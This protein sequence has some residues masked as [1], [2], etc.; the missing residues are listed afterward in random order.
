MQVTFSKATMKTADAV[1][2][3]RQD[4]NACLAPE[5]ACLADDKSDV[6]TLA[7]KL[8]TLHAKKDILAARRGR[9]EAELFALVLADVREHHKA[10]LAEEAQKVEAY[11][12][13]KTKWESYMET[14]RID[15]ANTAL[16]Y[17]DKDRAA[18]KVVR[19]AKAAVDTAHRNVVEAEKLVSGIDEVWHDA[20]RG[21]AFDP[22]YQ[23]PDFRGNALALAGVA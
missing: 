11:K 6:D 15:P 5:S 9:Q 10:M 17:G 19:D 18:P 8:A 3:L 21:S 13:A 2:K 20:H 12:D 23:R 14:Q 4:F 1:K 22:A 16:L 7:P